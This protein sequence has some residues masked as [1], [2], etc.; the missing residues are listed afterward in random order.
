MGFYALIILVGLFRVPTEVIDAAQLDGASKY[1]TIRDIVVPC[2]FSILVALFVMNI[3]G[4][5]DAGFEE[6]YLLY[7][8]HTL[9]LLDVIDTYIYRKGIINSNY[10][11][12]AALSLIKLIC[13][14]LITFSLS[15]IRFILNKD[16]K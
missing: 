9:D 10:G 12:A 16:R 3:A 6:I 2:A 8:T 1:E 4:I 5:L 15:T 11:L 14:L 7:S 13:A